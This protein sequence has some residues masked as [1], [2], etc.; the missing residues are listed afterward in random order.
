MNI[1][2]RAFLT[3]TLAGACGWRALGAEKGAGLGVALSSYAIHARA[4]SKELRDPLGFLK[5]CAERKAAGVQVSIPP[6]DRD[7]LRTIRQY[8]DR[9]GMF[10]QGSLRPPHDREDVA[11]F[12]AEIRA[13]KEAG[14][15]VFRTVMLGG[16]RYETFTTFEQYRRFKERS[17][18]SLQLAAPVL[19]RHKAQLAVE[20]HKDFQ[21]SEQV[22]ILGKLGSEY[23]GVVV[24]TGNNIS[25]LEDPHETV[26]ELAPLALSVHLKDMAVQE[27]PEGFLL[28]EVPFG[29]GFLDLQGIVN[30]LRK[31][32]PGLL[33]CLEMITRNPL[34]VPC[35]T[36]KYWATFPERPGIDLARGLRLVRKHSSPAPLP[37]I[38]GLSPEEQLKREDANARACL[39]YAREH[40]GF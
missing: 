15:T 40:L 20:N 39:A 37:M 10:L 28:A 38:S 4:R 29:Q 22:A 2:R 3:A 19:A 14:A 21:V 9:T 33:F 27:Y 30:Q 1:S 17:M 5:F 6:G 25:L 35:L 13:G 32:R 16:R 26:K 23:V 18:Q 11:R 12:E 8:L 36:E 31:A 24:D 34:K 7:H